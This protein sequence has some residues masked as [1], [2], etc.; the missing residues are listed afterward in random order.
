MRRAV[1]LG[2]AI[3]AP[4]PNKGV[5]VGDAVPDFTLMDQ[6][7]KPVRLSQFRGR[8]GG[9]DFVYTRCPVATACPMTMAKFSKIDAALAKEKFG[10]LLS[11]T[12][13][14]GERHAGGAARTSRSGS[15]P[16]PKRWKFL[17]GDPRPSRARR[18]ASASSTT[19]ITARSSTPR[20][21]RSSIPTGKLATI[22]YGEI[23]SPKRC[24]RTWRK[25]EKDE[26]GSGSWR[27]SCSAAIVGWAVAALCQ[28]RRIRRST[29][30]QYCAKCHGE[31]GKAQTPRASS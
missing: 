21:W 29:F 10:A 22:Y 17:T 30:K 9:R 26:E 19:R 31:D 6:T 28:G 4:E 3:R 14:P 18:S 24:S 5:A 2:G 23:G 15:A 20:R 16:I 7:G 8:A 11:I 25:R 13:D 1:A 12:V 27:L